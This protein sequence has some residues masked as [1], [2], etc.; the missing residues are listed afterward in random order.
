MAAIRRLLMTALLAGWAGIAAAHAFP[1]R[2]EPRVGA[3]LRS[4]PAEVRIWFDSKLEPGFSRLAV[5]TE[6]GAPADRGD[7]RVDPGDRQLLRASLLPLTPGRYR[8]SWSVLAVDGHRTAGDYKKS[9]THR[10]CADS[11]RLH[12]ATDGPARPKHRACHAL[13]RGRLCPPLI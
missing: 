5:T 6:G 10:A 4:V 8:V 3:V 9:P 7:S 12:A 11:V 13:H 2:S 1:E